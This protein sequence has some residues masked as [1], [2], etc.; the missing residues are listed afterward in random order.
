MTIKKNLFL[1]AVGLFFILSFVVRLS[2]LGHSTYYGDETKTLYTDKTIPAVKFMFDQR[3]GPVQFMAAWFMETVTGGYDEYWI[4]LPFAVAGFLSVVVFFFLAKEFMPN[5][6]AL[7]ASVLY[8]FNGFNVAFSR[9]AQ[10]QPFLLL[11]GLF[12]VLLVLYYIKRRKHIWLFSASIMFSLALLS[13]YD[14]IFYALAGILFLA[15]ELKGGQTPVKNF[16][17]YL[18]LP[19]LIFAGSFY[20]PYY[21]TGYFESNTV[22]YLSKRFFGSEDYRPSNS[23]YTISIYNPFVL[24]L[25]MMFV[26]SLIVG[27]K[28]FKYRNVLYAWFFIPFILF[29]LIASNPGTHILHYFVPLYLAAGIGFKVISD[30]MRGKA[31]LVLSILA[32]LIILIQVAVSIAIFIPSMRL[33]YPWSETTLFGVELEKAT[34]NYQVFLYGFPYDRG[35]REA[36]DYLNTLS[37]VRG[38]YTNDNS[39]AAKYYFMKYDFTPTGSNFLPR[40]YLD[41]YD[42]HE[43]VTTP[44]EFLNN[45]V[46]EKEFYV[47]GKLTSTL[48]RLRSL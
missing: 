39:V 38:I 2:Q 34:K 27:F 41:V 28:D 8:S 45:Y 19:I 14:G 22:N 18:V 6:F 29:E 44:Q 46:T 25:L 15:P 23:L 32:G 4:R 13:H 1:I 37:G 21:L 33:N 36:R 48:Y 40:F 35:F 16:L 20:I 17:I 43:F 31:K 5:W 30:L 7:V 10:Y 11:F 47:D 12:G 26:L 42:S 9:T 24:Y 3:K